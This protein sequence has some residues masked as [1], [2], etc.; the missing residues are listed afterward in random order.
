MRYASLVCAVLLALGCDSSDSTAPEPAPEP[1]EKTTP[2]PA[3]KPAPAPPAPAPKPPPEKPEPEA[4][5]PETSASDDNPLLDAKAPAVNLQS[6]AEFKA[7]FETNKGAFVVRVTRD[8]A[9]RGAD[10]FYSLVKNGFFDGCRFFRVVPGF[11]VQFGIHGDPK[12]SKAWLNA[13]INDDPVKET[14]GRGTISFATSG[15]HSRTT[16][17]FINFADNGRL[18]G[19]GFSAFGR[20]IEG[21]DVVDHIYAAYKERPNQSMIQAQGNAYL[22]AAFPKLDFIK[23]ATVIE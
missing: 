8:W 22:N 17:V 23:K 11:M 15:P 2:P 7:R 5:T 16:Q 1:P 12:V 3:E 21:M 4:K 6:P 14:N 9:P 13:K 10:R 18:D 20:V 19:M